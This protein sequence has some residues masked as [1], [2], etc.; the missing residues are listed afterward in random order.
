MN[1]ISEQRPDFFEGEFLSAADL[2]QLVVYLR[3]QSARHALGGHTWG[4]VAG[5]QLVEQASASGG[6]DV[7][8]L[9]GYAVDGFG[10]PIVV[11]NPLQLSVAWFNGQPSGPVQVWIRYDQGPTSAVR[12]G[13]QVCCSGGESYSRIAESYAIAVGS[14]SLAN[15]QSGI[16]V[17]GE[18]VDDARTAPRLFDDHGPILC[19]ASVPYQD[20]PLADEAKSYWMI[21]LG[22][23][24]WKPG[25]PDQFVALDDTTDHAK[26]IDSRRLRRYAGVVAENVYAADGLIRLRR[27]TA[28]VAG[29]V[30]QAV[31]DKACA[32]DLADP[33]HDGD[34]QLCPE[35][36]SP[37]ELVWVEGRLR[38]TDDLRVLAP[39]RLELRDQYNID[40]SVT[41]GTPSVPLFLRRIDRGDPGNSGNGNSN[42]N[43]HAAAN[44][45]LQI[46]I[47]KSSNPSAN[48]RLLIQTVDT[49]KPPTGCE[50]IEF[51]NS[52]PLLAVLDNGNIGI[53]TESPDQLLEVSNGSPTFIHIVD[54]AGPAELYVGAEN[55]GGVI[56]VTK[57]HD[58]RFRTGGPDATGGN[59]PKTDAYARITILPTGHVGI[60]TITPDPNYKLTIEDL[61]QSS[62]LVRT[63]D[64]LHEGLLRAN[65]AGTTLAA[66]SGDD[67]ILSA[68][69]DQGNV[70]IKS[71]GQVGINTQYPDPNV[72]VTVQGGA[73]SAQLALRTG[74]GNIRELL[75]GAASSDTFVGS[76]SKHDFRIVTNQITRVIVRTDGMVEIGPPASGSAL[77][78]NGDVQLGPSH[79][80][81]APGGYVNWVVIAGTI[82]TS[83]QVNGTNT[84]AGPGFS[85]SHGPKPGIYSISFTPGFSNTPN[86]PV[87]T[88]QLMQLPGTPPAAVMPIPVITLLNGNGFTVTMWTSSSSPIDYAFSFTAM[89]QR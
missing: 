55:Q 12:P 85:C 66:S 82:D 48:N 3:D 67:L 16:S 43:A 40:Y 39:A 59:D 13:F 74:N 20:L 30:T 46:A 32:D 23:V 78:V 18:A 49:P 62:L 56:A 6:V 35:G 86:P 45:D 61:T 17:S 68:N 10:R 29:T 8:L 25:S 77:A 71:S 80:Y 26:V 54:S 2:E 14:L 79:V 51:Q 31:V 24:N 83:G 70:W 37:K 52:S 89:V 58:L 15:Q 27:R 87:V 41:S 7:Y 72:D 33:S 63:N 22:Q 5:L 11:I 69:G 1:D 53:G 75:L 44:A 81:S 9:P 4:I 50:R 19:D 65:P 57:D 60:G 34:L 36:P 88:V 84:P 21:P 42:A 47:G 28:E 76:S 73:T 64:Q 38:V